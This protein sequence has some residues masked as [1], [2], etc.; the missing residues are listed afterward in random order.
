MQS[1]QVG[2]VLVGKVSIVVGKRG[3]AE[4]VEADMEDLKSSKIRLPFRWVEH[5]LFRTRCQ[6]ESKN[7]T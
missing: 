7:N 2:F 5:L 6:K 4:N 3:K 1:A